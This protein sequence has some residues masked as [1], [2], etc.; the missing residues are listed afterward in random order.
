MTLN[1]NI[2]EQIDENTRVL[3]GQA[4]EQF[5]DRLEA[6][7]EESNSSA[8]A[9]LLTRLRAQPLQADSIEAIGRLHT[10]WMRA[11]DAAA[12]RTVLDVDGM[13]LLH[14]ASGQAYAGIRMELAT[15]RLQI[16]H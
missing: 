4:L 3:K 15:Y 12:A 1:T 7:L 10:L 8:A 9:N 16:A 11:G 2:D 14:G 13:R 6:D 5:M